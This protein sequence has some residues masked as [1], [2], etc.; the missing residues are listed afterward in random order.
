MT[1]LVRPWCSSLIIRDAE[2]LAFC[3]SS[4]W[5]HLKPSQTIIALKGVIK[6]FFPWTRACVIYVDSEHIEKTLSAMPGWRG[7][8]FPTRL[9]L[10]SLYYDPVMG[11]RGVDGGTL[12]LKFGTNTRLHIAVKF[13]G[14]D[15]SLAFSCTW[16]TSVCCFTRAFLVQE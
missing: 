9:H 13:S 7:P 14:T 3:S 4:C 6:W 2:G 16:L 8:V 15:I 10:L 11:T 12:G 5:Q 1:A